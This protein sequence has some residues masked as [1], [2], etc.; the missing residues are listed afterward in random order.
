MRR[1]RATGRSAMST[2]A[3]EDRPPLTEHV[4]AY[5]ERHLTTYLRLLDAADEGADWGEVVAVIF[6]IDPEREPERAKTIYESHLA[7][8]RWMSAAG[9]RQLLGTRL[10]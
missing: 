5:D 7:R 2:P 3:F 9:Y 4:N 1:H 6:G 10:Q 8:A